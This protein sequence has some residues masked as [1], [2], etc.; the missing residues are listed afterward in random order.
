MD[1]SNIINAVSLQFKESYDA[2][3]N[4][5]YLI[6]PAT[7]MLLKANQAGHNRL[8]FLLTSTL[9]Q[10]HT[11]IF[12]SAVSNT[13]ALCLDLILAGGIV[14]QD[15][16]AVFPN[17]HGVNKN[18]NFTLSVESFLDIPYLLVFACES[19]EP[20]VFQDMINRIESGKFLQNII[21]GVI[22][23]IAVLDDLGQIVKVNKSWIKFAHTHGLV[24]DSSWKN[25][26]YLD[27]CKRS[28]DL[29]DSDAGVVREG[30]MRV[31]QGAD[32]LFYHEYPCHHNAI[33]MWFS[34]QVG[35]FIYDEKQWVLITH[36]EITASKTFER[37]L[38]VTE[39]RLRITQALGNIGDW[40][41]D[42]DCLELY[43]SENIYQMLG[44]N[45]DDGP[46]Q[47]EEFLSYL[48][49]TE[50]SLIKKSVFRAA[51][52]SEEFQHDITFNKVGQ[53]P[54]NL[55]MVIQPTLNT[56]DG[57]ENKVMGII[58][59]ITLRKRTEHSLKQSRE[60]YRH[61][62]EATGVIPWELDAKSWRFLYI[63]PQIE[64]LL[65]YPREV[66]YQDE[67]WIRHLHPDDRNKVMQQCLE[68]SQEVSK[69]EFQ[70]RLLRLSNGIVWVRSLVTAML[71]EDGS[72]LLRGIFV[73]VTKQKEAENTQMIASRLEATTT[74]AGGISHELNNL[75]S[76]IMGNASLLR[77]DLI[78][79]NPAQEV[80]LEIEQ[81]AIRAGDLA[82]HMLAY[83]RGGKYEPKQLNLNH[84]IAELL[85]LHQGLIPRR[86][87]L[88][89]E[90]ELSLNDI[91]AD[92]TQMGMVLINLLS[93]SIDAIE[94][95]GTI[96]I[97]TENRLIEVDIDSP[98]H[99][100]ISGE[101]VALVI[102]DDGHGM[103]N[104]ILDR[105]YEPFFSTKFQGR[106]LGLSAVHGVVH[107]HGGHIEIASMPD[108]GTVVTLL[109]PTA[110]DKTQFKKQQDDGPI[111]GNESIL[112]ID[113]EEMVAN[114]TKRILEQ[115][116]YMVSCVYSG[117]AGIQLLRS[118]KKV[119]LV[120]LDMVMPK[121]DGAETFK[122]I[123]KISPGMKVILFS[124]YHQDALAESLLA[125]GLKAFIQKPVRRHDLGKTIRTVLDSD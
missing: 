109:F 46:L 55:H 101:F 79:N 63:G 111:F 92:T 43:W 89:Q 93:N 57:N 102:R 15:M 75:M 81:A 13:I 120:L 83:A 114:V 10:K 50:A 41:Y 32:E 86:I 73:D 37:A 60:R 110:I 87:R 88:L 113:D 54:V 125:A 103:D 65:G 66:W 8:Q 40:S 76:I 24:G 116:G 12:P 42:L 77:S 67:F 64:T 104:S 17:H 6:E 39:D 68:I 51:T 33:K 36:D 5:V 124:G 27:I 108:Q 1:T 71:Q 28:F 3:H 115:L 117:E 25:I 19:N 98:A 56:K 53:L 84:L 31:M 35:R 78:N 105:I 48:E 95:N 4:C 74:L 82:K 121:M 61:L 34:M 97:T 7:G 23:Q 16:L 69:Q 112:V 96:T 20:I 72:V 80:L 85:Q 18:H 100:G 62:V 2:N 26:N 90:L 22:F 107:N 11:I 47:Y 44:F 118:G 58:Q 70:F 119:D 14:R 52:L 122:E 49:Y 30:I 99:T 94:N 45:P 29:G 21:D 91:I 59:N 123:Q 106:G 38:K 9:P